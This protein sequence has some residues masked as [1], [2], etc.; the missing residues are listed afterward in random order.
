MLW[1]AV[2]TRFSYRHTTTAAGSNGVLVSVL[3]RDPLHPERLAFRYSLF[4]LTCLP[5]LLSQ[6]EQNFDWFIVVD[7]EL[8][9]E[10]RDRLEML[11]GGRTRTHLHQYDPSEDLTETGWLVPYAP[12]RASRLLTTLLDDDDAL[13]SDFIEAM[14]R[15]AVA[16]GDELGSPMTLASRKARQWELVHSKRAPLGYQCAWHRGGWILS[17][18]LS[19]LCRWPEHRLTVLSIHHQIADLWFLPERGTA[20][21]RLLQKRW[22]LPDTHATQA[23]KFIGDRM[24]DFRKRVEV[25]SRS[26]TGALGAEDGPERFVDISDYVEAFV[27]CNHFG[28]DQVL[29]LFEYKPDRAPVQGPQDFPGVHINVD[30]FQSIAP[31][32]VKRPSVY[33]QLVREL[34]SKRISLWSRLRLIAWATVRFFRA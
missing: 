16:R 6:T 11:I 28:N 3:R 29:R 21:M 1:H 33:R 13:P 8:P 9:G 14:Q 32:F 26:E 23:A 15:A 20:L 19:L 5:S 2:I 7:R 25:C 27:V 34:W 12:S 18:G 31:A 24:D 22:A 30:R 4:E 10:W 17:T